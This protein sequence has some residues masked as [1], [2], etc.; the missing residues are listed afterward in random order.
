LTISIMRNFKNSTFHE[1]LI[2]SPNQEDEM[3]KTCSTRGGDEENTQNLSRKSIACSLCLVIL[4]FHL[5]SSI[6]PSSLCFG[7]L[8]LRIH[9]FFPFLCEVSMRVLCKVHNRNGWR[10]GYISILCLFMNYIWQ[11]SI[12]IHAMYIC[13]VIRSVKNTIVPAMYE[14]KR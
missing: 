13:S 2:V 11:I 4:S 8:I 3:S 10:Q 5:H 12:L 7:A 1:I 6:L 14:H 9:L